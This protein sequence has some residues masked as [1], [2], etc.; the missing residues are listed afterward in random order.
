[1]LAQHESFDLRWREAQFVGNEGTETAR[2][3]HRAQ[4]INLVPWQTKPLH[5]QLSQDID[6]IRDHENVCFFA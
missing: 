5:R 3:Q 4:S 6:W 2:V 1:M